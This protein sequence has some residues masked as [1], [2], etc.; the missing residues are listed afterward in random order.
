MGPKKKGG[1][2]NKKKQKDHS[3]V[4]SSQ[5]SNSHKQQQQQQQQ[6]YIDNLPTFHSENTNHPP[7]ANDKGGIYER[8]KECTHNFRDWMQQVLPSHKIDTVNDLNKGVDQI[9]NQAKGFIP[10]AED[11]S[12]NILIVPLEIMENL[13]RAFGVEK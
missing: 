6:V 11:S 7:N 1:R 8:Y 9:W 5:P 13:P 2:S 12:P 4:S 3:S 10:S